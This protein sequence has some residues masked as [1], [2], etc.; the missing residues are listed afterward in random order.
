[1]FFNMIVKTSYKLFINEIDFFLIVK[2]YN[3]FLE[4]IQNILKFHLFFYFILH[5]CEQL[6]IQARAYYFEYQYNYD[7][8]HNR[9]K[10]SR[11]L[12]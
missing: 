2:Y 4:M 1:M 11:R 7:A 8:N 5:V 10:K 12:Q 3:L 6:N 9:L